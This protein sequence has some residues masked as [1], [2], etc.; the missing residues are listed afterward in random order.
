MQ[1]GTFFLNF[2]DECKISEPMSDCDKMYSNN[3]NRRKNI[4]ENASSDLAAPRSLL[5]LYTQTGL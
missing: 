4:A 5:P 1:S 2:W 3:E